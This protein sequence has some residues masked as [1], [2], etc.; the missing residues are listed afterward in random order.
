MTPPS[1]GSARDGPPPAGEGMAA[2]SSRLHSWKEVAAYLGCGVRTVQRWEATEGLPV[3]R[4]PHG[5]RDSVYAYPSELDGWWTRRQASLGQ[6]G[7]RVSSNAISGILRRRRS[8]FVLAA[9]VPAAAA[10]LVWLHF[11]PGG[12]AGRVSSPGGRLNL[13]ISSTDPVYD[14]AISADGRMI[15][16]AAEEKGQTDLFTAKIPGGEPVRVTHD[17]ARESAPRFSP[18]GEHIAF[19]RAGSESGATEVCVIP[20]RG[21]SSVR[22]VPEALEPAWSPSGARL[23]VVLRR[24]GETDSLATVARDG[25][26]LRIVLRSDADYPFFRHPAWSPDGAHLAVCRSTGGIAGELWLAPLDGKA[27]RRLSRDPPSVFS[28]HPVFTPDG[29]GLIHQ[30]NR[31]GAHN[32][33]VLPLSGGG[34]VPLTSGAGPD[35]SPSVARDGSILFENSHQRST[36]IVHDLPSRR[37]REVLT[38][39]A[40]I[41]APAFSPDGRELAFSRAEPDGSWHIWIVPAGGGRARRLTSGEPPQV[42]PRFTPDGA[43]V[44]YHTWRA[45]AGRIWRVP[46]EG[47]PAVPLTPQGKAYDSYGDV[48]PDGRRLAFARTENRSTGIFVGAVQGGEPR[49]LTEAPST[50]PRWSPDGRW[51][52][53]SPSRGFTGGIWLIQAGGSGLR[54]LTATGS[55]PVW[56]RDGR[57]VGYI[58][59]GPDGVQHTLSVSLAGG[60]PHPLGSLR[61]EGFN[62]PFDISP[63]GK[64]LASSGVIHLS[65]EIWLLKPQGAKTP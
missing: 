49:R 23:A 30:S 12:R 15:V 56:S 27:P 16:Y 32:L 45:E 64:Q 53:F 1:A 24:L 21:G 48:S 22:L 65:S 14:P 37:T 46:R 20:T 7:K 2:R 28:S 18:D 8:W 39:T 13:L 29:R 34:A 5:K 58:D 41:W 4:H 54:R 55:F 38:H 19:T 35:E 3:H 33:W 25:T 62:N 40:Y 61:F 26:D 42:Y 43:A 6:A 51:I 17:G 31:G 60:Q 47:G 59:L 10:A 50:L 9:A 44:I 57:S 36:L 52:A 11:G 63:D